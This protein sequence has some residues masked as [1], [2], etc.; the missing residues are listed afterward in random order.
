MQ[1]AQG[2]WVSARRSLFEWSEVPGASSYQLALGG[3]STLKFT[4][5][6]TAYAP[7]STL[8]DGSYT[9]KVN[10]LDAGGHALG[11]S[12][13]R[14]FRVDGTPPKV[15]GITPSQLKPSSN[16]KATFS[17]RVYGVS[18]STMKLYK[19]S[20]G[21]KTLIKAKVTLSS[22]HK[23]ATLNPNSSLRPGKYQV[24]FVASKITDRAG[25][26]L[27]PSSAAPALKSGSIARSLT[28]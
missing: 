17:E 28:P 3:E 5:P 25:N 20:S 24:V 23:L 13:T 18:G 22:T 15:T 6:A 2:V 7:T 26:F 14:D 8:R 16:I 10:A 1:P 4:T 9:W 21:H 19:V 12:E 11:T 27:V